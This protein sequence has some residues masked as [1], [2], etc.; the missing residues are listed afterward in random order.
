[1]SSSA[2]R[3][4]WKAPFRLTSTT[5]SH[6]SAD[7][8]IARP[9]SRTPALLTSTSTGPKRSRTSSKA[10]TTCSESATSALTSDL[11]PLRES[12]A[13]VKPSSRSFSA[14]AAP[15]PREPP[16][17]SA[18]PPSG[19]DMRALLPAHDA[20][21]PHEARAERR[22]RDD[23]A[24][25]Q[26]PVPL[27]VGQGERDRRRRRVRDAVDV[28]HD[29]LGRKAELVAGGREDPDV[30]LV[31]D[32]EVDVV[33][34][35]PGAA[36]RL[37]GRLDHALDRVAV[38]LATLHAQL[39]VLA[40]GVEHVR[41]RGVGAEHEA[42]AADLEVAARDDHRAGAVAEQHG[43]AAVVV[44]GDARER[45][46]AADEHDAGAAGLDLRGRLVERVDEAG[47]GGVDVD[48]ARVLR[49]ELE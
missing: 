42:A 2:R 30:R 32:E 20:R 5:R 3:G 19:A 28:D 8:R 35:Q 24:G 13:T 12:V 34:R 14:I 1:M 43:R 22:Q 40:L 7:M 11:L 18:Q 39:R 26:P 33:D 36:D 38:D 9:S 10:L 48:G 4:Q 46:R 21:A 23:R 31:G 45:L 41:L 17:T 29:L 47:A 49:A 44:V 37:A 6:S 27:G 16:V 25:L 15:M